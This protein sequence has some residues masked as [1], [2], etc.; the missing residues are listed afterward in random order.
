MK[1]TS[2]GQIPKHEGRQLALRVQQDA[3]ELLQKGS[4]QWIARGL[5]RSYGDSALSD[6]LVN[7]RPMD[8]L[9]NFDPTTGILEA[10]AGISLAEILEVIVPKGWF[11]PV[12]PGTQYV[13]LGGAIASDVH[14]KNHHLDGTFCQHLMS[15]RVATTTDG[16]VQCSMHQHADLFKATCAGMGLTGIIL[17]AK[18]QLIPI[19]SSFLRQTTYK[20]P[21]LAALVEAFE[22]H[23]H[24]PY[25]VAWIDCLAKGANLGR[26]L[27]MVAKHDDHQGRLTTGKSSRLGI[28]FNL[29]ISPIT[30][31]VTRL[32]NWL[33]YHR[34][35]AAKQH[36]VVHY[37]P[38]FYPLDGIRQWNRLYGS[39][40]FYQ[41]Q[42][43]IPYSAGLLGI[44]RL[45]TL[46]T[47]TQQASFLAVLKR[48]GDANQH[49]LSFP[50]KGYTLAMD[51]KHQPSSEALFQRLDAEVLAQGGRIY[52]AKDARM[53]EA[54][55]KASYPQWEAFMTVRRRYGAHQ[56]I[57]SLQST[58][59]GLSV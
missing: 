36:Q 43:V 39:R 32:F 45:L 44:K 50:I 6:L 16:I 38:F 17:S 33:Y 5:G 4:K 47:E 26:S 58:R 12:T 29:P 52:L 53:S 59:L 25:S 2:W 46:V 49:Y 54:T 14:G 34:Q 23:Q 41:Y 10:Q 35:R 9:V 30:P 55:F 19:K 24:L 7:V 13:T 42:C 8:Y 20:M 57:H 15:M 31:K 28:P 18:L 40:G 37:R 22:Q 48:L 21:H 56:C 27:F 11:L 51:F 3:T 1:Y